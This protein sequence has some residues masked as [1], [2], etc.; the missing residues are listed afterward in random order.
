MLAPP[1]LEKFAAA[2]RRLIDC[3]DAAIDATRAR[4]ADPTNTQASIR[5]FVADLRHRQALKHFVGRSS[6]TKIQLQI[7]NR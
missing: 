3:F 1:P 7:L 6:L 2:E 5:E 4:I